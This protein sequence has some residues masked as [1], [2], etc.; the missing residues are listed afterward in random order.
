MFHLRSTIGLL[1]LLLPFAR[2][3]ASSPPKTLQLFDHDAVYA[4]LSVRP[5][6]VKSMLPL[7]DAYRHGNVPMEIFLV[8]PVAVPFADDPWE[9]LPINI[10]DLPLLA[11]TGMGDGLE[12]FKNG[13][14]G[15]FFLF[16]AVGVIYGLIS[17]VD[18][19]TSTEEDLRALGTGA[20]G[21]GIGAL[22]L[23]IP[24]K[25]HR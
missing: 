19:G 8:Q 1:F 3:D 14:G 18:Q 15:F 13:F 4:A 23:L 6:Q 17:L 12:D 2:I 7:E 16:G 11:G 21:L 10:S 9:R 25:R 22:I 5:A 24:E 20:A